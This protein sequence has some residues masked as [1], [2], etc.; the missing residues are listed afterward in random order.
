M[1]WYCTALWAAVLTPG[2]NIPVLDSFYSA[3]FK[4]VWHIRVCDI[5][6]FCNYPHEWLPVNALRKHSDRFKSAH[7]VWLISNHRGRRCARLPARCWKGVNIHF[8]SSTTVTDWT[9]GTDKFHIFHVASAYTL[10]PF[11][12]PQ[13]CSVNCA[14]HRHTSPY[15]KCYGHRNVG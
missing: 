15:C 12:Q 7:L 9:R 11:F 2:N 6:L 10:I 14:L 4:S 3:V 13:V 5:T 1:S 8:F